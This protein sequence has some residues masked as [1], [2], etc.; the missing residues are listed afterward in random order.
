MTTPASAA[1]VVTRDYHWPVMSAVDG[2]VSTPSLPPHP[3]LPESWER[4]FHLCLGS[5]RSPNSR[6]AGLDS[7]QVTVHNLRH[8]AAMLRKQVGDDLLRLPAR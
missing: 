4:L 3:E 2:P 1:L 7:S 6:R 5:L 8:T